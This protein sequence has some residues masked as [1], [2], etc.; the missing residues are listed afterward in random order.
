MLRRLRIVQLS[1][2][3]HANVYTEFDSNST[4]NVE[5][6]DMHSRMTLMYGMASNAK[7]FTVCNCPTALR[8]LPNKIQHQSRNIE[9]RDRRSF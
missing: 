5:S 4:A 2:T 7:K 3:L 6:K 1:K 8:D 9:S